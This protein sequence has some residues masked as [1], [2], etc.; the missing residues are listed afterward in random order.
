MFTLL[1]ERQQQC[2]HSPF[3]RWWQT[4]ESHPCLVLLSRY[5]PAV[6]L[7]ENQ[8]YM[9]RGREH[10]RTTTRRRRR[11]LNY[12]TTQTTDKV[13][14]LA[15]GPQWGSIGLTVLAIIGT[16]DSNTSFHKQRQNSA[17]TR[18]LSATPTY[19]TKLTRNVISLYNTEALTPL[20]PQLS[21]SNEQLFSA[22]KRIYCPSYFT[23]APAACAL[24][25]YF[26]P[27]IYLIISNV[28]TRVK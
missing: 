28:D 3:V 22:N 8:W 18:V 9:K 20:S 23:R 15:C 17:E 1:A 25:Q 21:L 5:W 24:I 13:V 19:N 6:N 12:R 7:R 26:Q 2:G 16:V 4:S 14:Q 27:L 10:P 11:R